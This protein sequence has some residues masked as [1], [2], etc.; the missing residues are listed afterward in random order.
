MKI[1]FNRVT[2]NYGSISAL[3]ELNLNIDQGEFVFLVGPSGAG[4]STILKLI[5]NQI[6]PSTGS[7]DFEYDDQNKHHTIESVRQ[8]IGVIFQDYQLIIDKTIE[9]NIALAL[10]II[11]LP[12]SDSLL[13]LEEVLSQVDLLNRRYLF[14]N[15]LS[16]GELQRA[17]LARAL[18]IHPKIILADEPTG[19]LDPENA[20]NLIRLLQDINQKKHTTILMTTHNYDFV[21]SLDKRVISLQKGQLISD[22]SVQTSDKKII[23]KKKPNH[24]IKK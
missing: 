7:I 22:S 2:K 18:A 6:R 4:K 3:N 5:L 15:Q 1:V 21:N 17:A 10:D 19:N 11:N 14:P 9:E 12:R 20:W 16:G 23:K 8:Q 24:S 13:R